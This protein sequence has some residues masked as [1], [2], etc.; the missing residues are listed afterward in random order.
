VL[1]T[2]PAVSNCFAALSTTYVLPFFSL[3]TLFALERFWGLCFSFCMCACM[4]G[5]WVRF[6]WGDG[7]GI[8][9]LSFQRFSSSHSFSARHC[10]PSRH[11]FTTFP[12]F[13]RW[14]HYSSS[15]SSCRSFL[16]RFVYFCLYLF[17][18]LTLL[19]RYEFTCRA[20]LET[21][22]VYMTTSFLFLCRDVIEL[23]LRLSTTVYT[24]VM[25]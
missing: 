8:P 6:C 3:L 21:D 24:S 5:I 10:L 2:R 14:S 13:R 16:R 20:W 23:D 15:S 11:S 4:D 17:V 9:S 22:A 7:I 18:L 1:A 12:T 25:L 19:F